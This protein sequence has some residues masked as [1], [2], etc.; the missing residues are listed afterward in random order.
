MSVTRVF[1]Y[2]LMMAEPTYTP[3]RNKRKL[4]Q[5]IRLH[6]QSKEIIM[7]V[8]FYFEKMA[9]KSRTTVKTSA[10]R[11]VEATGIGSSTLKNILQE[12]QSLSTVNRSFASPANNHENDFRQMTLTETLSNERFITSTIPKFI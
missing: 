3:T 10:E 11:T 7:N 4:G 9:K 8:Y 5:G 6:S 12:K 2:A 1:L